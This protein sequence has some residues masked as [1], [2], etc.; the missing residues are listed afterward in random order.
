MPPQS[1]SR[2]KVL[3]VLAVS[4]IMVLAAA[5]AIVL[6]NWPKDAH[7]PLPFSSGQRSPRGS[8]AAKSSPGSQEQG[9]SQ[10]LIVNGLEVDFRIFESLA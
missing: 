6:M 9:E 7:P 5:T 3:L 1:K 2:K 4:A 8:P 10:K